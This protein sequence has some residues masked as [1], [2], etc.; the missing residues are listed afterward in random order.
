MN[1]RKRRPPPARRRQLRS[2]RLWLRAGRFLP[3]LRSDRRSSPSR[4]CQRFRHCH[5]LPP[6]RHNPFRRR[7]PARFSPAPVSPLCLRV[8]ECQAPRDR[9]LRP[10]RTF[11]DRW[12]RRP[13]LPDPPALADRTQAHSP[14]R[15][16]RVPRLPQPLPVRRCS[17]V[18]RVPALPRLARRSNISRKALQCAPWSAN[19]RLVRSYRPGPIWWT[20]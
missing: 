1:R 12:H 8:R 16:R 3:R 6:A 19:R 20:G 18:L 2:V 10:A 4:Q 14:A 17:R 11:R 9:S 13:F 7:G 5:S 15:P